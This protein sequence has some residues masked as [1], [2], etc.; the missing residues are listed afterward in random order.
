MDYTRGEGGLPG[1]VR[2]QQRPYP[3]ACVTDFYSRPYS[4]TIID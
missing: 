1:E 3:L 2:P 4:T